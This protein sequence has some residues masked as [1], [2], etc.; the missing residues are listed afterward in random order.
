MAN[1]AA[2]QTGRE[3]EAQLEARIAA[4]ERLAELLGRLASPAAG[5]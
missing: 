2:R 4:D 1:E 5:G 3:W